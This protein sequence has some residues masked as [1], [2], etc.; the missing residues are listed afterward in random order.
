MGELRYARGVKVFSLKTMLTSTMKRKLKFIY[1]FR[2]FGTCWSLLTSIR[3]IN[4]TSEY[5]KFAFLMCPAQLWKQGRYLIYL[6][7]SYNFLDLDWHW[8]DLFQPTVNYLL[9][10]TL[11]IFALRK[12]TVR[13]SQFLTKYTTEKLETGLCFTSWFYLRL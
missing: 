12:I 1:I 9:L 10:T 13:D 11:L 7:L 6:F 3:Y 5:R 2:I 4:L 8:I